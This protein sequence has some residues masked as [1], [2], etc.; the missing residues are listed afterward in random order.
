MSWKTLNL[1]WHYVEKWADKKPGVEVMVFEDERLTWGD[2]KKEMDSL[3]RAYLEV[4]VE[5]GDRVAMLSMARNEFLTT[6]MAAGKV[7]AVW[8]GLSPKFT[9]D[10]L[11]YQIGDSKPTVLIS[12]RKYLDVDLAETIKVLLKEFSCIKK[13]L[14]I[15]EAVE[16][17]EDFRE[18]TRK[19]RP[20]LD[21]ALEKRSAEVMEEDEALLLYT[22]GSTGKP[23]GVVHTHK[24]IIRNIEI[25]VKKFYFTETARGLLHFPIN[26]VAADTEIGFAAIMGGGSLVLMDKF[27][28]GAV[29]KI[30]EK[31]RITVLGQVPVM[32]LLEFKQ[33]DFFETDLSSIEGFMWAGA[34]APKIMIDVLSAICEKTGAALI[35]GYGSTEVA[36]FVTYTEKGDDLETVMKTAGK[37]APPFELKIVDEGR[38]MLPDGEIGEIAVRGP[39]LMKGY[40]NKPEATAEVIDEEGWYYTSD[41]AYRDERGYLYITGR[42]SEMF[43]TGG[44]NVY[45]RE[46]EETLES[47]DSVLFA[48]VMGVNDEIYQE[49]G[50]AFVMLMPGKTATEEELRSL[51]KSRLANFKVPKKFFIRELLPLLSTGKVD[52]LAL[53][54]E[55]SEM[56]KD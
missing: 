12:L 41:L 7:G 1:T 16:G 13:A 45:P 24:S 29:L 25:E 38:K 56:P 6:Y 48:A 23:K 18:F 33:P 10:E 34:A 11:R 32:Y 21:E 26:H 3:A 31:E 27:D 49:V 44:E 39:F 2:F 43:K 15:G 55:I 35:T 28:P 19:P 52:K 54:K 22:S 9:L 53:K 14:V 46:I 4:G 30:I 5:K 36:G 37:I 42:K 51:C 47:H 50:W 20:E 17:T 8:L 40:F